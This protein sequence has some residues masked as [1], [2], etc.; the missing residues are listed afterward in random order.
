[1]RAQQHLMLLGVAEELATAGARPGDLVR[2]GRLKFD[3]VAP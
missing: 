1:M 2:I 3:C